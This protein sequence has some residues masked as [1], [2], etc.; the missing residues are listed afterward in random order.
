MNDF[1]KAKT[2]KTL[3]VQ[4]FSLFPFVKNHSFSDCFFAIV[5]TLKLDGISVQISSKYLHN[6]CILMALSSLVGGLIV[7]TLIDSSLNI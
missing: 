7:T 1:N 6:S 4:G 2:E 3:A 5:G